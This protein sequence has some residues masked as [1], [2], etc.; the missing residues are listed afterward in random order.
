[1]FDALNVAYHEREKRSF[2][3]RTLISLAFPLGIIVFLVIAL[4]GLVA[5]AAALAF[6]GLGI[7]LTIL[8]KLA[9]LPILLNALIVF[10][11]PL[12]T[13]PHK[14]TLELGK[15]GRHSSSRDLACHL[16]RPSM[17]RISRA[18]TKPTARWVR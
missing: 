12:R 15:L 16:R 17:S 18:T 10:L 2:I 6:L 11:S 4:A 8:L 7:A 5:L 13:K 3:R 9:R 14:R 1:M